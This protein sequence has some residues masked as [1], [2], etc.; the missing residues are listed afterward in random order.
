MDRW[1]QDYAYRISVGA[2]I[3]LS[4]LLVTFAVAALTVGVQSV[5][6]ALANP[7]ESLGSE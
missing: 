2:G 4:S 1:L 3:F 5:R 7:I 6:A